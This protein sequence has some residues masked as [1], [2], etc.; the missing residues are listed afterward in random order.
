MLIRPA[1]SVGQRFVGSAGG[2]GGEER[3]G[4]LATRR[5]V[6]VGEQNLPRPNQ[7]PLFR[8]RFLHLH[9][10]VGARKDFLRAI[11]QLAARLFVVR[12]RQARADPRVS[13]HQHLVA[14]AD[15]FLDAYRKHRHPI[16][17]AFHLFR[18]THN[19]RFFSQFRRWIELSSLNLQK[20]RGPPFDLRPTVGDF[21]TSVE[22]S[23]PL[24]AE[25][26]A[27]LRGI[28]ITTKWLLLALVLAPKTAI[29]RDSLGLPSA[30]VS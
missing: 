29:I 26:S 28:L 5:Q 14:P 23:P 27:Q 4:Q 15:Q 30:S 18:H 10:E 12:I 19:H 16:F 9:D 17:V 22:C 7:R 13:L 24:A 6:K 1:T 3:V 11:D 21:R 8:L 2:A 25:N 20:S